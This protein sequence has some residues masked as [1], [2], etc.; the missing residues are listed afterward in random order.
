MQE[1]RSLKVVFNTALGFDSWG[2]TLSQTSLHPEEGGFS[3][4]PPDTWLKVQVGLA[5]M[6]FVQNQSVMPCFVRLQFRAWAAKFGVA[7][8][9]R[10][11]PFWQLGPVPYSTMGFLAQSLK[12]SQATRY[13]V[14]HCPGRGEHR[15]FSFLAFCHF[16]QL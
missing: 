6:A 8:N 3:F 10:S 12:S 13:I 5:F 11:L 9:L 1:E 16:S 4:P 15:G 2:T 7:W 14:L